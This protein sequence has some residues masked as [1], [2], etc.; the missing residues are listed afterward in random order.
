MYD[1]IHGFS[2]LRTLVHTHINTFLLYV[3]IG[4]WTQVVLELGNQREGQSPFSN[5]LV[6]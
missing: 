3:I 2:S 6:I 1:P 5:N 4:F